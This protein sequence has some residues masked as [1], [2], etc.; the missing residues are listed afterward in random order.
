MHQ[1]L[2]PSI[3]PVV[4]EVT[5][6]QATPIDNGS[7]FTWSA[8]GQSATNVK[9]MYKLSTDVGYIDSAEVLTNAST[10]ATLNSLVDITSYNAKLSY[11]IAG[12]E[13]FSNVETFTTL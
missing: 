11:T 5:D 10:S 9:L 6:F 1:Q 3:P 2:L 7:T 12:V 13:H 4:T 8:I